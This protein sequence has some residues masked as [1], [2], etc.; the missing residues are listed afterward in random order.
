MDFL[1]R[2][3][4][5]TYAMVL[6]SVT[7][8]ALAEQNPAML[9]L[10]LLV[11]IL[12]WRIVDGPNGHSLPRWIINLGVLFSS[13]LLFYELVLNNRENG[14]LL[15]GLGHFMVAILMC[16]MFETKAGRDYTQILTLSLLIMVSGTIFGTTL[17]FGLLLI[18][19]L[20]LGLLGILMFFMYREQSKM[21]RT[22]V[23]VPQS[24]AGLLRP[25]M[26]RDIRRV[27]SISVCVLALF[28]SFIFLVVPRSSTRDLLGVWVL[29]R[30]NPQTG[31]SDRVRF[32]DM[33]TLQQSDATV[34][35][36]RLEQRGLPLG[37]AGLQPYFRGM[38]LD[39]YYG[40]DGWQRTI[41]DSDTSSSEF[42]IPSDSRVTLIPRHTARNLPHNPPNYEAGSIIRQHYTIHAGSNNSNVL[43]GIY[44]PVA[45]M[46][47]QVHAISL[48]TH[49][50]MMTYHGNLGERFD[51]VIDSP[52]IYRDGL[53]QERE[54]QND[55]PKKVIDKWFGRRGPNMPVPIPSRI[56]GLAHQIAGK[57]N[58][59][60]KS[61]TNEPELTLQLCQSFEDYLRTH[62][63]YSLKMNRIDPTMDPTEDFLFNRKQVGGHCE[64]FASSMVMLCRA[65]G[66]N[67]RMVTGYHGG[68]YNQVGDYYVVRQKYAHAW[69]EVFVKE[70]GWVSFDPSPAS[71]LEHGDTSSWF[72]WFKQWG[73]YLQSKWLS[74]VV[75]FDNTARQEIMDFFTV[76]I[77][78]NLV[79][80]L[81]LATDGIRQ[82]LARFSRTDQPQAMITPLL[83]VLAICCVT[84]AAIKVLA[85]RRG[86]VSRMLAHLDPVRKAQ[87]GKDLAFFENL[88][89]L[90]RRAGLRRTAAQTPREFANGLQSLP[91]H[92]EASWLV[93]QFYAIRFGTQCMTTSLAQQVQAT[94]ARLKAKIEQ[95]NK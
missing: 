87:L 83:L 14:N 56:I 11:A 74:L 85:R 33:G 94:L 89:A 58:P 52:E 82:F 49:D 78:G 24:A 6:I 88:L 57:L 92:P 59:Q 72:H 68:D 17:L 3:R 20:M 9:L 40:I 21:L 64:Y 15:F 63:P 55:W 86:T 39:A 47:S 70:K 67:A 22:E 42:D 25:A 62:Y 41:P 45:I 19:Y 95:G 71:S 26:R 48:D 84:W 16:K 38:T 73:E 66:M 43:F 54:P 34:M 69:M 28:A 76:T 4:A 32:D 90:L 18:A 80:F 27:S 36:V 65:L 7:A 60:E 37:S 44:P 10:T 8:F 93:E 35:E 79:K 91:A 53:T 81:T 2:L 13:F 1:G 29:S 30:L 31:F 23:V 61:L 51:Y 46:S 5:L 12:S 77:W 75:F 50:L